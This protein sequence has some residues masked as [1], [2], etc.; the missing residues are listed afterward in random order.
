VNGATVRKNFSFP[1]TSNFAEVSFTTN[2]IAGT[3]TIKLFVERRSTAGGD[4]DYFKISG[5]S[6]AST[7]AKI[8]AN[9]LSEQLTAKKAITIF[10]NPSTGDLYFNGE[11][12][13]GN[14]FVSVSIYDL[15]GRLVYQKE[16]VMAREK[17]IHQLQTGFYQV[18]LSDKRQ[19]LYSGKLVVVK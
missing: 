14:N 12:L 18:V 7:S 8:S 4:I 9:K 15:T 13:S 10:P 3:N 1:A 6:D 5:I 19:V 2:F 11:L 16:N 17:L